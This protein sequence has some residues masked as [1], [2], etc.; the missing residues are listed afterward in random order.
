MNEVIVL[1][2]APCETLGTIEDSITEARLNIRYVR[3]YSGDPVPESIDSAAGLVVMGGPMGV[4]EQDQ[5]PFLRDELRLIERTLRKI[6]CQFWEYSWV[7]SFSR[8]PW[9][10]PF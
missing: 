2:H 7:A 6:I 4:Y 1:Q 3:A 5:F 9:A 8:P 10:S